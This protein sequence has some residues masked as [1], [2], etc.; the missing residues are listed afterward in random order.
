MRTRL[1]VRNAPD[2]EYNHTLWHTPR[3]ERAAAQCW[4]PAC[5][6]RAM[7][8]YIFFSFLFFF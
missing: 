6:S 7:Y 8:S 3:L 2:H 1:R 5:G 4:I